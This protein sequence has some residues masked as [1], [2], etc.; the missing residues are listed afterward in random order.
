MIDGD[1]ALAVEGV[2]KVFG[3]Q[4]ALDGVDLELR[5][6]EVHALLGQ[7]GSG[8]STLIKLLAGYHHPDGGQATI[9]GS[10]L[11]LGD[12]AD[13]RAHGIR[14]IHQDLALVGDQD[15]VDNL[16]LGASYEG[17]WWLSDRKELRA[18]RAFLASYDLDFDV[19]VPVKELTAAQQTM[20]AIMRA[21]RGWEGGLGVLVL[22]EPTASLPM[23]EVAKLFELIETFRSRG[24]TVLYVTHRLGEVFEIADRVT[25]FRDGK[26][27]ATRAVAELEHDGLVELIVGRTLEA[28]SFEGARIL[29]DAILDVERLTGDVVQDL[30]LTVRPGEIVGVTGL[31]GSGFEELL[32]LVYGAKA[33]QGG[34]VVVDGQSVPAAPHASV[35][36]GMAFAPAD[37]KNLGGMASWTLRENLTL[38][39]LKASGPAGWMTASSERRD[40]REWL[41]RLDVV[42]NDPE[43]RFSDLSGGNQQRLVLARWLRCDTR[44]FLLEDP[45]IGVDAGGKKAIYDAF[46]T[47]AEQGAGIL[48]STSDAEEACLV[49]DRILVLRE[50]RITAVLEGDHRQVDRVLA[51]SMA[52]GERTTANTPKE[53]L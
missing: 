1:V 32:P 36:A 53:A 9:N 17:R 40:A 33:R 12:A 7:N 3:G 13:A 42:P 44:V 11:K 18:A 47:A 46:A 35:A 51:E 4:H 22:D 28:T 49:C 29:E 43:A 10:P 37:R 52:A 34:S 48:M 30:S 45:T 15:T 27:V 8:K 25:V 2:S 6:G 38:P 41:Q 31:V 23:R 5:R 21:L 16:G 24:G 39:M 26:R 14:F 19:R 50:G 20:V